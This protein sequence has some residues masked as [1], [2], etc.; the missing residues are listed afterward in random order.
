MKNA[1]I[2][3]GTGGSSRSN[4]FPWLKAE[5]EERGWR[6]WVPDLP[7][8]D[9]PD[10]ELYNQFILGTDWH[11][12]KESVLIGHSSGAVAILGLLPRLRVRVD[13]CILVGAFKD[14]LGWANLGGLFRN[15]LD[16]ASSRGHARRFVLVHSDNDPY[17]P[18]EHAEYLAER[19]GGKLIVKKGE[20]H[21]N[22]EAGPQYRKFPLLLEILE[23][24]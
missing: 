9:R 13:T 15:P 5:L 19:L 11:F 23:A 20:G 12:D 10:V 3:H 22:M 4:W 16:F 18:L 8:A 2:V 14:D 21:F 1:L 7:Q 6:V 17:C 24:R